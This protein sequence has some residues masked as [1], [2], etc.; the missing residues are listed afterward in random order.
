MPLI[1]DPLELTAVGDGTSTASCLFTDV[2]SYDPFIELDV[3]N[4]GK[5]VQHV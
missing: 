5:F 3:G 4:G 1:G 2:V